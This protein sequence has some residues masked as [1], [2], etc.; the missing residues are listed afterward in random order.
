MK[1]IYP[2]IGITI[3][4]AILIFLFLNPQKNNNTSY[5]FAGIPELK[6]R[7]VMQIEPVEEWDNLR[8]R[9]DELNKT[10]KKNPKDANVYDV[11]L[12]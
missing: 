12:P 1:R 6:Q 5:K 10:L 3:A 9:F 8:S 7:N 11:I 2:V 4:A